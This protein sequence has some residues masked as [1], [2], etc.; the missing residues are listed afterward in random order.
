M[1]KRPK[2]SKCGVCGYGVCSVCH[3]HRLPKI[4]TPAIIKAIAEKRH[5]Y[6]AVPWCKCTGAA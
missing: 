5:G 3:F 2:T 6:E 1:S 4:D